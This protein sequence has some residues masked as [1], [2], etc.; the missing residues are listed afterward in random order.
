MPLRMYVHL[1]VYTYMYMYTYACML[2]HL[3]VCFHVSVWAF[4]PSAHAPCYLTAAEILGP[5][6]VTYGLGPEVRF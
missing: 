3:S 1:Y 2:I 5:H 4:C 6:P